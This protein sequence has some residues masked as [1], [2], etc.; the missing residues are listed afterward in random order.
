[1]TADDIVA[2][3]GGFQKAGKE[4]RL[5][6][7]LVKVE[8]GEILDTFSVTH[9]IHDLFGAQDAL[10]DGLAPKLKALGATRATNGSR[11]LPEALA[12]EKK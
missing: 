8:N 5:T 9:S 10:A 11:G 6:A 2:G 1:M 12:R 3:K 4:V 7:R